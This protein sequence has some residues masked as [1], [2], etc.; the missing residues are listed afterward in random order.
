VV[1][2]ELGG[3]YT[4]I[5]PIG[6]GGMGTVYEARH[7]ATGRRVAVKVISSEIGEIPNVVARF[8]AEAK[9]AGAIESQHIAQ[10]LDAGKD[11]AT[12]TPFL[13]M[14][15]LVGE[16]LGHVLKREGPLGVD[17][18]L[19]IVA[20]ACVGLAKAHRAGVI[21]RDIKPANLFLA[22]RDGDDVVVKLLDFGIAKI[23]VEEGIAERTGLTRS[24]AILGSPRYMSPE[25][26]R[27]R[28]ALDFRTDLWSLGVVMYEALCGR[29][30]TADVD[31]IGDLILT[32]CNE[33]AAVVQDHA[34]WVR[35]EVADLVRRA[36]SIDPERRFQSAD[37]MLAAIKAILPAG[38]GLGVERSMIA[39]ASE[40]ERKTVAP[41]L[42]EAEETAPGSTQAQAQ[43]R[44]SAA[45]G[46]A[47]EIA[48]AAS[49]EP[50]PGAKTF[51]AT[52]S[53]ATPAPSRSRGVLIGGLAAAA[54]IG[55]VVAARLLSGSAADPATAALAT[56][57]TAASA[58]AT[59]TATAIA[60][61]TASATTTATAVPSVQVTPAATAEPTASATATAKT[62]RATAAPGKTAAPAVKKPYDPLK[63]M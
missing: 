41:R 1:G 30:P 40:A 32:V 45:R 12:G 54:A 36:L 53:D 21:H 34:P 56:A 22:E 51:G 24:G 16:D 44:A 38:A 10:V 50:I 20:Q 49:R 6:E 3:R 27:G 7:T 15:F 35:P 19:R 18:A 58:T 59:A 17:L 37:E 33:S 42:P 26:A 31:T 60:T 48:A 52:S 39:G 25:Q 9:A 4:L 62:T 55:G 11:E 61:M 47:P 63:D 8:E 28:L 23:R 46:S 2:A 14:E 29:T 57:I 5:R 13:A 43:A